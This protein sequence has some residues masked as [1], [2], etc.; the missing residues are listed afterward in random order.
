MIPSPPSDSPCLRKGNCLSEF[1]RSKN[2]TLYR[3]IGTDQAL[4]RA[5]R[6]ELWLRRI[7]QNDQSHVALVSEWDTVYGRAL[8]QSMLRCLGER[9]ECLS[10]DAKVDKPWLHPFKYLRGLDGQ[11]PGAKGSTSSDVSDERRK[12]PQGNEEPPTGPPSPKPRERAEGDGQFD[13]LRR[14]GDRLQQL[15]AEWRQADLEGIKAVGILGS[16]AHD[17]LLI[18]QALRPLF[19]SALFFTTDLDALLLR[20]DPP[21]P[22]RNLLVASSFGLRLRPDIQGEVPP[23]RSSYQT[24]GF[25]AARLAIRTDDAPPPSWFTPLLFE[26]GSSREFQFAGQ[27]SRDPQAPRFERARHD[28]EQC[29]SGLLACDGIH[30]LPTMAP[31]MTRPLSIAFSVAGLG[32][33]LSF[34]HSRK[35]IL[36]VVDAFM[37]RSRSYL[38][39][40]T[41]LA[42]VLVGLG[43]ITA[44]LSAAIF[45]L[46]PPVCAWLTEG[47]QP[48]TVLERISVWPTIFLRMGAFFLCVW[49]IADS[50]WRLDENITR[51]AGDLDLVDTREKA[52]AAQDNLLLKRPWLRFASYFWY[53]EDKVPIPGNG[54]TPNQSILRFWRM[55]V[56]QGY[57]K[58]RLLRVSAGVIGMMLLWLILAQIFGNPSPP[59]RGD[60]SFRAYELVTFFL[61]VAMLS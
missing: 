30:P 23:F 56:H 21:A 27:P 38:G 53:R 52:R 2:V 60:V 50:W 26:L 18:L 28:H 36:A 47:G 45:R 33:L 55:Y 19:P 15:D 7:K 37:R 1:F 17:K 41:R 59:A 3:T 10:A 35:K 9:G 25:L 13:Y 31:E 12:S 61:V 16:D 51:I 29:K 34:Q 48:I 46:W 20:P 32:L 57:W 39:M 5:I 54:D 40:S 8:P 4:A 49:F 44:A 6:D 42:L 22:A 58:A 14:L 43:L 11:T 24:A